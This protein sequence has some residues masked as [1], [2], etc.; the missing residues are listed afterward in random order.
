MY[1]CLCNGISDKTIRQA[2]RKHQ[3]Q[4]FQQLRKFVPVGTQ[5]GKCVRAARE[6]MQDELSQIPEFKEIA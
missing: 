5:C 4:S 1:I 3:P 6:I 2:V